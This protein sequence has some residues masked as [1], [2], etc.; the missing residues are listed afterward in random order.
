MV[1]ATG[2]DHELPDTLL[3]QRSPRGLAC[4]PFVDMIVAGYNHVRMR[5]VQGV[6]QR[7]HHGVAAAVPE[8]KRGLWKYA[9]V[10]RVE[11]VA[12]SFLS[13]VIIGEVG[14]QPP[15][16]YAH[17]EFSAMICQAPRL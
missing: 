3:V 4:E 15:R 11:L 1:R 14:S 5:S 6:P 9:S 12:K 10:H 7:L 2:S 17:I 8:L 13:Q 16:T